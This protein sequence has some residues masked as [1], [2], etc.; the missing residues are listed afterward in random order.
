M[1]RRRDWECIRA[2]RGIY[3]KPIDNEIAAWLYAAFACKSLLSS[4]SRSGAIGKR[5]GTRREEGGESCL[6]E[7]D[8]YRGFESVGGGFRSQ[9]PIHQSRYLSRRRRTDR[10]PCHGG[11]PCGQDH[12]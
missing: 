2:R 4:H 10:Q 9:I 3:G 5:V 12:L 8:A 1:S 7:L 11:A 6:L